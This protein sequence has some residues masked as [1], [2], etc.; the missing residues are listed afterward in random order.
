[1]MR[2]CFRDRKVR[3]GREVQREYERQQ[4]REELQQRT[5]EWVDAMSQSLE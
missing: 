3:V 5:Q 4:L 1:M 2:V